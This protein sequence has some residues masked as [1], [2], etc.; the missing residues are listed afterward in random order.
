MVNR[1]D[2]LVWRYAQGLKAQL[3]PFSRKQELEE[4]IFYRDGV[5]IYRHNGREECF[6]T[7]AIRLQGVH[8]LENIMAAL[9]CA[10]LSG[11]R[12]DDS[13]ET[14]Q[15]FGALHHRM[16]FVAEKNG[17]RYYE[18]SKATNVG[19]VEKALESFD[20]ITLIAG[21]KD[22]G[23]SYAPLAPLVQGAGAAPGPDRR[24]GLPHAGRTG[25][26]DRHPPGSDA[27]GGGR[28]GSTD[29]GARGDGPDVAGLLQLRHVPRLR[30]AGPTVYCRGKGIIAC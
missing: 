2:E 22:K 14:V 29:H 3:F 30:G 1:D 20:N 25:A 9:A 28:P 19:S 10:L 5:I 4:G 21:G 11:C 7:K 26:S 27:G 16:E 15:G 23:G 13:F 24:G 12:P 8:N 6:P 18:D 17:V